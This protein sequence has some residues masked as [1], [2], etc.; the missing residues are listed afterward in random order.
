M[1]LFATLMA[2]V[3]LAA[4]APAAHAIMDPTPGTQIYFVGSVQDTVSMGQ[5]PHLCGSALIA[6]SWLITAKRCVEGKGPES[7]NVRVGS[8]YY[9][10][11]G[12]LVPAAAIVPHPTSDV[13]LIKLSSRADATPVAIA[14]QPAPPGTDGI[15]LGWGQNCPEAGC[16]GPN[17]HLQQVK[18]HT[19]P[20]SVCGADKDRLCTRYPNNGGPCFGD[21]GGPMVSGVEG[22]YRLIG[23]VPSRSRF[24]VSCSQGSAALIEVSALRE[25]I[26][27]YTG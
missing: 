25:W 5:S 22:D 9:G 18:G 6:D 2:V 24:G 13:A 19:E 12:Q 26:T 16:G 7:F 4:T 3:L 20:N 11:R 10:T 1:K 17:A 15:V 8:T 27:K 21:E 23:L 14:D